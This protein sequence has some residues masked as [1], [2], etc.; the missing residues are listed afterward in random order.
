MEEVTTRQFCFEINWPLVDWNEIE[1]TC[2]RVALCYSDQISISC[3]KKAW[4]KC[5]WTYESTDSTFP[6][7]TFAL[8][9][10]YFFRD[11]AHIAIH[12][13]HNLSSLK[14]S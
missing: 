3:Q 11:L 9:T 6:M 5:A 2:P 10:S 14:N 4:D 1:A 8:G 7:Q 13:A 12:V